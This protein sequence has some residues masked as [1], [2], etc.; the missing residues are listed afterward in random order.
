MF[1]L[2]PG[3]GSQR[4]T[5]ARFQ[6][7]AEIGVRSDALGRQFSIPTIRIGIRDDLDLGQVFVR[8]IREYANLLQIL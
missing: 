4:L 6:K 7:P 5:G 2:V 3:P 8:I 1:F